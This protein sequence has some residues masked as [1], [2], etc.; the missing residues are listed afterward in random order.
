MACAADFV[1]AGL[2]ALWFSEEYCNE[3]VATIPH[4]KMMTHQNGF[5]LKG[6]SSLS[7]APIHVLKSP[8]GTLSKRRSFPSRSGGGIQH[9]D[10]GLWK[11]FGV[12]SPLSRE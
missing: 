7:S 5:T 10:I 4:T 8:L 3:V 2:G 12:D 6:F 1:S 9:I 11:A